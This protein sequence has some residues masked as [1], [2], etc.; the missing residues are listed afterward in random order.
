MEVQILDTYLLVSSEVSVLDEELLHDAHVESRRTGL[1]VGRIALLWLNKRVRS[2]P[3]LEPIQLAYSCSRSA[4]GVSSSCTLWSAL[5]MSLRYFL[6]LFPRLTVS[7][8]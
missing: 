1:T 2:I 3:G 8:S 5:G 4:N 6:N 7:Q